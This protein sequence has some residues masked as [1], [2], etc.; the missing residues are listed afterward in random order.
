MD[1]KKSEA[2]KQL[3]SDM[4]KKYPIIDK[5][6]SSEAAVDLWVPFVNGEMICH[7]INLYTY[8]QGFKYAEKTPKIKYLLVAQDTGN[9]IFREDSRGL[10]NYLEMNRTNK[11]IAPKYKQEANSGTGHNLIPF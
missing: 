7:E 1:I 9:V 4:Q 10:K 5:S 3:V 2:Y 8:W 6:V 11:W